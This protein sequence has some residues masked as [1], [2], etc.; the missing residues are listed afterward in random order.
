METK[1]IDLQVLGMTCAACSSRVERGLRKTRG[2]SEVNVNLATGKARL[3][4]D[5]EKANV[6]TFIDAIKNMGYEV[7]SEKIILP[8]GGMTCA[9]CSSRVERT[10]NKL[11]GVLRAHVNLATEKATVEY[12]PGKGGIR[13]HVDEHQP[14][15]VHEVAQAPAEIQHVPDDIPGAFLERDKDSGAVELADPAVEELHPEDGL[16]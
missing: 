15:L 11:D 4:Y 10:L 1:Q 7:K 3:A 5:P 2:V 8:V 9:A 14:P 16:A 12:L 6:L 13:G